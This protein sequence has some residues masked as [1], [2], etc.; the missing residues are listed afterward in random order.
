MHALT[1][2][3]LI[4]G[5]SAETCCH[6]KNVPSECHFLCGS[7]SPGFLTRWSCRAKYYATIKT[8]EAKEAYGT[9][10]KRPFC[11]D[12]FELCNFSTAAFPLGWLRLTFVLN[13]LIAS[14]ELFS[15]P[16]T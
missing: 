7:G 2:A 13:T 4:G 10:N 9:F 15:R 5:D 14:K 6:K 11:L 16:M 1:I 12:Y 3:F 8:C